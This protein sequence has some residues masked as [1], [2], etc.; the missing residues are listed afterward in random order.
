M[1]WGGRLQEGVASQPKSI[2]SICLGKDRRDA[3][4]RLSCI[5]KGPEMREIMKHSGNYN[6]IN[7]SVY[8][9]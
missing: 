5:H 1:V 8:M 2:D 7:R 4:G 6:T 9:P 3:L